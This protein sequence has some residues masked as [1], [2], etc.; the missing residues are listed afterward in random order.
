MSIVPNWQKLAFQ[1]NLRILLSHIAG[2]ALNFLEFQLLA[3]QA[4]ILFCS[5]EDEARCRRL[6][7]REVQILKTEVA[8]L[9]YLVGTRVVHAQQQ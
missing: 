7:C 9:L 5:K 2:S 3:Q 1:K 4:N 8:Q 6:F